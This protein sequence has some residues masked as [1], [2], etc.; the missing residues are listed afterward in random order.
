MGVDLS[1][2]HRPWP[3]S[4]MLTALAVA[5]AL[6]AG[7]GA[8]HPSAGAHTGR[9]GTVRSSAGAAASASAPPSA[10]QSPAPSASRPVLPRPQGALAWRPVG[11][12]VLGTPALYLGHTLG[13]DLVWMDTRLVRFEQVAGVKDPPGM[14]GP[15]GGQVPA[16]E[17]PALVAAFSSG[18]QLKDMTGG[19]YAAGRSARALQAGQAAFVVDRD[20][21]PSIGAWGREVRMGPGVA[22]VRQNLAL[23]LDGGRLT[24]AV[25]TQPSTSWGATIGGVVAAHRSGVCIDRQAAL[26]FVYSQQISVPALA[27]VMLAAGCVRGMQLDINPEWLSFNLYTPAP[28][29]PAAAIGRKLLGISLRPNNR[30]LVPDDRDFFAVYARP[31]GLYG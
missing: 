4:R 26:V 23:L 1:Y 13:A 31:A 15:G 20:G 18:F 21:R 10:T 16:A 8:G 22:S 12:P 2:R 5:A 27:R 24:A 17:R 6:V 7:C 3:S 28:R 25:R 30:Y 19:W 11:R 9:G 29:Q 14:S